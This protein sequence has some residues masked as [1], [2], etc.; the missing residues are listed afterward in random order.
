MSRA[1]SPRP[2]EIVGGRSAAGNAPPGGDADPAAEPQAV[3][4]VRPSEAVRGRRPTSGSKLTPGHAESSADSFPLRIGLRRGIAN[5][6]G[7][8]TVVRAGLATPIPLE[9][10]CT[11]I[12]F[13]V[14]E[15]YVLEPSSAGVEVHKGSAIDLTRSWCC[16][17][18]PA[19]V[20]Q[21]SSRS[22]RGPTKQTVAA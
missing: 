15:M 22:R 13:G 2:H 11:M 6:R 1:Y 21:S 12:H 17:R 14:Y 4:R 16:R 18:E 8:R 9:R 7:P 10:R 3:L 19:A 20:G 5:R